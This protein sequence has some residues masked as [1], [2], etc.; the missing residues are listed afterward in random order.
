MR[1]EFDPWIG[2]IPWRKEWPLT[3]VFL[4]EELQRQ[5]CLAGNSPWGLKESDMTEGLTHTHTQVMSD[6][7][8]TLWT[9]ALQA[10]LFMG[11]LRQE[12]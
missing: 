10:P 4:P 8:A 3:P 1:P 2:K 9:V 6:S 7:F 5:K 12:Y 11:F